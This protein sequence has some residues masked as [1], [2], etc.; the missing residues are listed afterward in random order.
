MTG[1]AEVSGGEVVLDADGGPMPLY[2]ARPTVPP[3]GAVIVVHDAAGSNF[4]NDDVTRRAAAAGY[5]AVAPHLYY[6][7]APRGS[8][9][10]S[11][12][13]GPG[14]VRQLGT[15]TESNVVADIRRVVDY[16]EAEGFAPE[17]AGVIGFSLGGT[18]ASLAG[19]AIPFGAVV[20]FYGGGISRADFPARPLLEAAP[21]LRGP[22]LG[23]Y[24]DLDHLTPVSDVEALRAR[25]R[26]ARVPSE[27]VRYPEAGHAFHCDARPKMYHEASAVDGWWRALEWIDRHLGGAR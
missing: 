23:L 1:T 22:W 14:M 17:S 6:R 11:W 15:L 9:D 26:D 19:A 24:G 2:D 12:A 10:L 4:H 8:A 20:S 18:V 13:N 5:R 25:L 3:R 16:L 27:I 7:T 21:D